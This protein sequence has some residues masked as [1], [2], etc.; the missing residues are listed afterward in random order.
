MSSSFLQ[1]TEAEKET[2]RRT[3]SVY[4]S[5]DDALFQRVTKCLVQCRVVAT[6]TASLD[7]ELSLAQFVLLNL[8]RRWHGLVLGTLTHV[9]E[10]NTH[11]Y[12]SC[13]RGLVETYGYLSWLLEKPERLAN[14]P[15]SSV[16]KFVN[17]AKARKPVLGDLYNMLSAVCHPTSRSLVAGLISERSPESKSLDVVIAFPEPEWQP[18]IAEDRLKAVA[19]QSELV[20]SLFEQLLA[21]PNVILQTPKVASLTIAGGDFA[22]SVQANASEEVT[23]C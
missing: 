20:K 10:S 19:E 16:G 12:C 2:I 1:L 21:Q 3:R 15:N 9:A 11:A 22:Q 6:A 18:D 5:L 14:M 4:S 7:S 13:L 8:V 23:Q 17:S